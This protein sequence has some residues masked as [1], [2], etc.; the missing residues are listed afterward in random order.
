MEIRY[1]NNCFERLTRKG[2]RVAEEVKWKSL[3][4]FF[5]SNGRDR[6]KFKCMCIESSR[7]DKEIEGKKD[8]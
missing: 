4:F 6:K 3:V 1:T 8:Y 7:I 2:E 5:F